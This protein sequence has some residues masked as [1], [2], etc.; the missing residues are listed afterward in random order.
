[1]FILEDSALCATAPYLWI[2]GAELR[3]G[4]GGAQD[5]EGG[6]GFVQEL[7]LENRSYPDVHD[8]SLRMQVIIA[9]D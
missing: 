8:F 5:S 1:M 9:N 7:R 6:G 2:A 3:G 4:G